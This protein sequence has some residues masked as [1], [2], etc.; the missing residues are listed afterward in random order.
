[1]RPVGADVTAFSISEPARLP[2]LDGWSASVALLAGLFALP[3]LV[4]LASV[5]TPAGDAWRHLV[6][7]V[8]ASYVTNSIFLMLGVAAGV[9]SIGVTTAWMVTNF[10]FPLRRFFVWAQ[11]LPLAMPAYII[12]YTYTGLLDYAGPLQTILRNMFGPGISDW[13]PE[14]RSLGG[15]MVML[16]LVLY[17]YVYLLARAAFLQQSVAVQDASRLLG[18]D[19]WQSFR[20]VALPMA[21]PAIIAGTS[22]AL[23]ETLADYGT[24]QY[25]GVDT[26]TIGIFRTWFGLGDATAAAQLS[27]LLLGFVILL[28]VLELYSRRRA[29]YHHVGSQSQPL[30]PVALPGWRRYLATV[31][32]L[33]PLLFGFV[34]PFAV[35][36]YWSVITAEEMIDAGFFNLIMHSFS[37]AGLTALLAVLLSVFMAYGKRLRP[38]RGVR[39]AVRIAGMGYA[40]PGTVIAIGV[41]VPMAWLDKRLNEFLS[42][43]TGLEPGLLLSGTLFALVFAYLVRFLAVS[44]QTVDAGL[45]NVQPIM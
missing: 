13:L 26:F 40:I 34:V 43:T 15:A 10:E 3:V 2:R 33:L 21:R 42:A 35:L 39:G 16:S 25:F 32:C 4:V 19:A 29:R 44:L 27:S 36:A 6:D 23:M 45:A 5:F 28:L 22:L 37:L 30:V 31:A 17:P 14:V 8:L 9:L 24:V 20:L 11:L 18:C 7:T 12:A 38:N 41:L 1:M